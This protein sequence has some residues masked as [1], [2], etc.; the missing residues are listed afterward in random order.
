MTCDE[1]FRDNYDNKALKLLP[2]E[3]SVKNES[4]TLQDEYIDTD[5]DETKPETIVDKAITRDD[6]TRQITKAIREDDSTMEDGSTKSK[7]L[8]QSDNDLYKPYS[9]FLTNDSP[10]PR[11]CLKIC[12]TCSNGTYI[13]VDR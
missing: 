9:K 2:T 7:I 8:K 4:K 12:L 6:N 5:N 1:R 3:N 10:S 13:K 11:N